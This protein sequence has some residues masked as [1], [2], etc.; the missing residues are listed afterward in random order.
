M[1]IPSYI[2]PGGCY[3]CGEREV[4]GHSATWIIDTICAR[5]DCWHAFTGKEP[6]IEYAMQ[7]FAFIKYIAWL[8]ETEGDS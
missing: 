8:L 6:P 2:K 5:S 3:I 4:Y 7:D 1:P